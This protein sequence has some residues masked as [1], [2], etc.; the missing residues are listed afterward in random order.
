[1]HY[2]KVRWSHDSPD[3]PV[4]YLSELGEDRYETRKVQIYRDGRM[5]WADEQHETP[6]AGVSE[7]EFP[8]LE[9]IRAQPE[10]TAQEITAEEFNAAWA[11]ATGT[12]L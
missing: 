5:E 10:F 2:V 12:R 9:E 7:I 11:Q 1:M 8:P 6:T 3:E 4:T